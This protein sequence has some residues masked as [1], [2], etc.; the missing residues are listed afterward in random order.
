MLHPYLINATVY[1]IIGCPMHHVGPACHMAAVRLA[2]PN[3]LSVLS[4]RVLGLT[5]EGIHQYGGGYTEYVART[6]QEAPGGAPTNSFSQRRGSD[7]QWP[8]FLRRRASAGWSDPTKAT[9]LGFFTLELERHASSSGLLFL[10]EAS[11]PAR[12]VSPCTRPSPYHLPATGN[13]CLLSPYRTTGTTGPP[14]G[15]TRSSSGRYRYRG[16][17]KESQ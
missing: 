15:S 6:G 14:H 10:T 4:N 7:L 17:I 9:R 3:F 13:R 16:T 2:R 5:P 11:T 1:L 8:T 12:P